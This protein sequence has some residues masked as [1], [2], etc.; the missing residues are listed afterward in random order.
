MLLDVIKNW[1]NKN[2]K[3]KETPNK[4]TFEALKEYEAM[5]KDKV[6]YKRYSSFADALKDLNA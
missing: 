6:H 4:K 1:Y 2:M 5:K 3:K